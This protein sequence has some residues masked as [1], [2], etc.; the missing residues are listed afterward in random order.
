MTDGRNRTADWMRAIA[1]LNFRPL[2]LDL[3]G[4][5]LLVIDMQRCFLDGG[6]LGARASGIIPNIESLA[7]SFRGAGRPVVFTRHCDPDPSVER[8]LLAEWWGS[9]IY[10]GTP[11]SEITPNLAPEPPDTVVVKGRY[12]A[13]YRTDLEK[14][15]RSLDVEDIVVTG[16]MTNMCCETT[17]RDAFMRD[18]RVFFVADATAT[19]DDEMQLATLRN[20]AFGFAKIVL[21]N[22]ILQSITT[23]TR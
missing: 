12:S 9:P 4:A 14:I 11:E 3:A 19:A 23:P 1:H 21:T 17:A 13:F 5:C 15:L 6:D 18:F 20:L 8:S 2:Q 7:K 10:E 22:D 16:T